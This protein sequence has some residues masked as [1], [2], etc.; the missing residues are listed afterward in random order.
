MPAAASAGVETAKTIALRKTSSKSVSTEESPINS[1]TVLP[2]KSAA[3]RLS[4]PPIACPI[5]TVAPM[6]SPTIITVV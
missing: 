4:L 2:V 5:L 3:L 1:V 6:A